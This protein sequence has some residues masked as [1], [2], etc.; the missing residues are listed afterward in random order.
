MPN[1]RLPKTG[2]LSAASAPLREMLESQASEVRLS[3]GEILFEQGD[4]GDAFYA[5]I[6]GSL[7]FSILSAAG[8]KLSL[9]LM[10][11]GAVFGAIVLFDP[12]LRTATVT[13][14]EPSRLLRLRDGTPVAQSH[15]ERL[16]K[17][18]RVP[19]REQARLVSG[20]CDR[21]ERAVV[22]DAD[23]PA[24]RGGQAEQEAPQRHARAG[25]LLRVDD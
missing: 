22:E 11:P 12:G 14:A 13:A 24:L 21:L 18:P 6:A 5:I 7:E 15:G 10:R 2:F 17:E 19:L 20:A 8:R 1:D 9:D 23:R 16:R 4:T 25:E 3:N